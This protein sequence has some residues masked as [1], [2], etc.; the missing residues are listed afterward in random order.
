MGQF[1]S[2]NSAQHL[3]IAES[4]STTQKD[5]STAAVA[6]SIFSTKTLSTPATALAAN[7]AIPMPTN[8]DTRGAVSSAAPFFANTSTIQNQ[9]QTKQFHPRGAPSTLVS[10]RFFSSRQTLAPVPMHNAAAVKA[11]YTSD[12]TKSAPRY[13]DEINLIA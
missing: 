3:R 6:Q 4:M 5:V 2:I 11:I 13:Q 12:I 7:F 8:T 9:T 10:E 1:D